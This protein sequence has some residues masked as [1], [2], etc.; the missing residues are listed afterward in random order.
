MSM[1]SRARTLVDR[2]LESQGE[3]EFDCGSEDSSVTSNGGAR[4]A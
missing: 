2:E 3:L 4:H 1:V